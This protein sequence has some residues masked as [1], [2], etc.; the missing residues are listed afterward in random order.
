[1]ARILTILFALTLLCC[2]ETK[3][4]KYIAEKKMKQE[5]LVEENTKDLKAKLEVRLK[6][7]YEKKFGVPI[8]DLELSITSVTYITRVA[9]RYSHI[10][11][12]IT[13][14]TTGA[15]AKYGN[16]QL[17]IELD[18]D[19][20]LS[21]I[22][23]LNKSNTFVNALNKYNFEEEKYFGTFT[24]TNRDDRGLTVQLSS[25]EKSELIFN[26]WYN[27]YNSDWA[28]ITNIMDAIAARVKNE[29]WAKLEAKLKSEYEKRFG[30]P[31]SDF[32][33][34]INYVY[35]QH[36]RKRLPDAKTPPLV[37]Y[38]SVTRTVKG[39]RV[40]YYLDREIRNTTGLYQEFRFG[41]DVE[42]ELD[43]GEWL[44]FVNALSKN[45]ISKWEKRYPHRKNI[46][47]IG[48]WNLRIHFLDKDMLI[49]NGYNSP[50]NWDEF[51]K[52]IDDFGQRAREKA[53]RK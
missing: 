52:V 29:G 20:W 48:P 11:I 2:N 53:E 36:Y 19:E 42:L 51:V 37:I 38:M 45:N 3:Q 17:E 35:F 44:D 18:I 22:N 5:E 7:E 1:M 23:A 28:E 8:S 15:L 13:R 30:V 24:F 10:P 34:S 21:F 49:S 43:I 41:F 33:L 25:S 6:S 27:L 39:A 47:D 12:S 4:T 50:P 31:I 14:T 26:Q 9:H 16:N 40:N 32:E 46:E